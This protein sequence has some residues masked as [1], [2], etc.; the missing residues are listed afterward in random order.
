MQGEE[1]LGQAEKD[2]RKTQLS[3][4]YWEYDPQ[5]VATERIPKPMGL[6]RAEAREYEA[7]IA[8]AR[9]EA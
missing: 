7:L 1:Y 9:G 4:K 5:R 6:L 3:A 2:A 8:R